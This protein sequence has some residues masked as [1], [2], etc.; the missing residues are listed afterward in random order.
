MIELIPEQGQFYKT[1]LHCHT[2][3]SDGT[4]PPEEVKEF[5]KRH[6]YSA[7]CFTDHEVLVPHNDLCDED[8]IALHG[9]EVAVKQDIHASTSWF[10]PVYHFNMIAKTQDNVYLPKFFLNN[11]MKVGNARTWLAKCGVYEETI[12]TTEYDIDWINEYTKAVKD[13][14]FLITYNHP[15]WSLQGPSDYIGL[16]HLHAIEVINGG[17]QA[18]N[19]NTSLHYNYMLRAGRRLVPVGGDDN[20]R[21]S[22]SLKAWTM[23]KAPQLSYDALIQ[24]YEK[25]HCY[26]TEGPEILRLVLEDGKIKVRTSSV[27]SIYLRTEG[28]YVQ[29]AADKAAGVT[30]AEFD[31]CPEKFGKFFRIEIRDTHG[32]RAFSNAYYT[33]DLAK[34]R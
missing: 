15:E 29:E 23:I 7:V 32:Y 2:N 28:R 8:F 17:C 1:N 6:G 9:Y 13:A 19:D 31:Y 34:L 33:D 3:I 11:P 30:E 16:E 18:L 24:A 26:A 4:R 27:V 25:G 20:H 12:D 21:E 5:Y 10:Q 14:G 22:G